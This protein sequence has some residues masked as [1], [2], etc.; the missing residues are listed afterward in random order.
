MKITVNLHFYSGSINAKEISTL[1]R[2]ILSVG[3][4]HF[5]YTIILD[6]KYEG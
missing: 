3:R 1:T 4:F 5:I 6:Y 2:D